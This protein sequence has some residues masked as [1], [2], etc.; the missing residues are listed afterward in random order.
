MFRN[1]LL[2]IREIKEVIYQTDGKYVP[3]DAGLRILDTFNKY[4]ENPN[5]FEEFEY[6]DKRERKQRKLRETP[7]FHQQF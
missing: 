5:I 1:Q 3:F 2:I 7:E 4:K 6:M